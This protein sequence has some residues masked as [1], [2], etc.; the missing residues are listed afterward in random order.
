MENLIEIDI[1]KIKKNINKY[2]IEKLCE[3]IVCDRYF[4]LNYVEVTCM[5]ELAKRR[6]DGEQFDFESY[7]DNKLKELPEI[8][9][10]YNIFSL[11]KQIADFENA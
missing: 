6:V 8:E 7:I 11:L 5:E 10:N 3:M 9:S 1:E 4:K 2:S